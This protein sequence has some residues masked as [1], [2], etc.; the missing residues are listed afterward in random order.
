MEKRKFDE[1]VNIQN[2]L[3]EL[4][5]NLDIIANLESYNFKI[6]SPE[7]VLDWESVNLNENE[8]DNL[9][10]ILMHAVNREAASLELKFGDV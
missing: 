3:E 8:M 1:A 7:G 9:R 5:K 4:D 10:D 6:E 2:R